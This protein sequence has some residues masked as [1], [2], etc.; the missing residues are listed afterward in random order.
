MG[1]EDE[2][3]AIA[4]RIWEEEGRCDGND[5]EHWSKAEAIWGEKR[6]TE[7]ASVDTGAKSKQTTK[8]DRKDRTTAPH[9]IHHDLIRKVLG[10]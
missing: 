10:Q 4:Y 8:Q 7:A 2:I 3:R 9:G 6:K 1:R 5:L